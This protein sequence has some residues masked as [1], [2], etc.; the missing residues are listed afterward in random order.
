MPSKLTV[1]VIA[2]G[3]VSLILTKSVYAYRVKKICEAITTKRGTVEKCRWVRE[4]D[5][6]EPSK[7]AGKGNDSKK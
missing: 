6:L 1:V 3:V 2:V 7:T 5:S 4:K